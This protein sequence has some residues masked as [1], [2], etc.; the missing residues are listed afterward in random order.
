MT[1]SYKQRGPMQPIT[2]RIRAYFAPVSRSG[3]APVP[4][5]FD[6]AKGAAFSLDAPPVPWLDAGWIEKFSRSSAT[7]FAALHSGNAGAPQSQ[8]RAGLSAQVAFDFTAWGK[9][10][11]ALSSG[12]QHLNILA[13]VANAGSQP[14][15]G[16]PVL[17]TAT[18]PGST[19]SEI[20][21]GAGAVNAFAIGDLIAVDMDYAQQVGYVGSGIAGAFVKNPADVLFDPNYIRRIT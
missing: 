3:A 1:I 11:M 2:R 17:P 21:I 12:S 4:S 7:R 10:Q 6:P 16:A 20:V 13:E 8:F 19:A 5:I 15:G 9:L 18:L 14:S